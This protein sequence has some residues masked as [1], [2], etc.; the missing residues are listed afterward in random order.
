MQEIIRIEDLTPAKG[1]EAALTRKLLES[2]CRTGLQWIRHVPANTPRLWE[3]VRN[4]VSAHV[5]LLWAF[6]FFQVNT[7]KEGFFVT[8]DLTTMTGED[9]DSGRIICEVA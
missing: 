7:R 8:S 9:S 2:W 3:Q 5:S 6:G 1:I 4:D